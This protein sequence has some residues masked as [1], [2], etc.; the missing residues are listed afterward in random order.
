[1]KKITSIIG[2]LAIFSALVFG[3]AHAYIYNPTSSAGGPSLSSDNIW[4]GNNVF[5]TTTLAST[6]ISKLVVTGSS[7]LATTTING[8]LTLNGTFI[9]RVV[10]YSSAASTTVNIGTTDIA[11]TTI[12][13]TTTFV[14]PTG[15][16]KDGQM[17]EIRARATTTHGL[18]WGTSFA[19][20]TDLNNISQ[21]AS[22]TTR[23]LF[24]YR[25]DVSKWELV[26]LLKNY[27]N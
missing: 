19:S 5:A 3:V 9:N 4:T 14:N 20:S 22:G 6:T 11:T 8:D 27:I 18:F 24:E 25:Q 2:Y 10:G 23:W 26:G 7:T 12:T 1:M 21:I 16:P 15:S 17:F 13:A